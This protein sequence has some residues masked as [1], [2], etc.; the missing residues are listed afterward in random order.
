MVR[1]GGQEI[2]AVEERHVGEAGGDDG[3][4]DR[5]DHRAVDED[6]GFDEAFAED[7]LVRIE[8]PEGIVEGEHR[9]VVDHGAAEEQPLDRAAGDAV[10]PL[11]AAEAGQIEGPPTRDLQ[12]RAGEAGRRP[13][14]VEEVVR[15][16]RRQD[17]E[18]GRGEAAGAAGGLRLVTH[19]PPR[20][21]DVAPVECHRAGDGGD[22]RPLAASA[23][24]DDRPR[25]PRSGG[26]RQFVDGTVRGGGDADARETDHGRSLGRAPGVSRKGCRGRAARRSSRATRAAPWPC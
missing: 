22:E 3:V 9:R 21:E 4:I 15:P 8:T 14:D 26:E 6:G 12:F 20:H 24:P 16:Q 5:G 10:D 25:L 7:A 2:A 11:G 18:I 13:V 23:R 1:P 17:A 19:R